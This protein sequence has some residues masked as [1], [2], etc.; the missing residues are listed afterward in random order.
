MLDRFFTAPL[1]LER[2]RHGALSTALD[3]VAAV[4]HDRGYSP[5]VARSYLSIAGHFSHWL[6]LEGIAPIGLSTETVERF[7]GAHLPLCQCTRP[8]G[9]RVHVRAALGHVQR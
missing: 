6:A 8:L 9:M 5:T 7:R 3:D 4:L 1:R 2:L